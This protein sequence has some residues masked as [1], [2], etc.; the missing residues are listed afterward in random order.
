MWARWLLWL[1]DNIFYGWVIVAASL[2]IGLTN[3]GMRYS[4]GV[5]FN[6]IETE[7]YLSRAVTSGIFS[8]HMAISS[9]ASVLGGWALDRYGPRRLTFLMGILTGLSLIMISRAGSL[10]HLYFSYSFLLAF[11][12]SPV[13]T[14]VNSTVSR[15]FDKRRGFALGISGAGNAAGTFIMAP[16]SAYLISAFDWRTA[17]LILAVISWSIVTCM[18]VLLKKD[19]AEMGLLPDGAKPDVTRPARQDGQGRKPGTGLSLTEAVR[20]ANFWFLFMIWLLLSLSVHLLLTH[21]VPHAV[22][23]GIEPMNAAL[24]LSLIGAASIAGRIVVG[25]IS[26]T[27]G[28]KI[29]AVA[30]AL[31]QAGALT[32]LIWTQDLWVFYLV[33]AIFGFSWGGLS[34]Q[35]TVLVSDV[36]GMDDIG[37]IMGIIGVGW[38]IGAAIGP[39]VG[40]LVFDASRSY[41]GAFAF[42]AANML[43]ATLIAALIR[44]VPRRAE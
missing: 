34:S 37:T 42:G 8:A 1:H 16:F 28:R 31:V 15:W 33:A 38:T 11:G 35:V 40:G 18:S 5:F 3:Y 30:S 43:F 20:T 14:V 10:W 4:F 26:D 24:I 27:I 44:T 25:R 2:A 39:A 29:P 41:A 6:S 13:F 32:F 22:D 36:F 17:F 21:I 23:L 19:P 12:T 9:I 7:F